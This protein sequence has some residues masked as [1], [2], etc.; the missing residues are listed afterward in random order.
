[1]YESSSSGFCKFAEVVGAEAHIVL[2]SMSAL[3]V[4]VHNILSILCLDIFF[5]CLLCL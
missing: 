5:E 1:M 3:N 4:Q 2:Y